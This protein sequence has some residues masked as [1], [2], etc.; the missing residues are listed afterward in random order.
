MCRTGAVFRMREKGKKQ[1]QTKTQHVALTTPAIEV[2]E[3][4]DGL[5]E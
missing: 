3:A 1:T 5:E 4:R 2:I